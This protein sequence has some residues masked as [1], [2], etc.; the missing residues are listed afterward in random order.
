[1]PQL[2]NQ[3]RPRPGPGEGE[4]ARR[5]AGPGRG[6]TRPDDESTLHFAPETIILG[7]AYHVLEEG[8][9]REVSAPS[10]REASAR[11]RR[12]G[13]RPAIRRSAWRAM[14]NHDRLE[15]LLAVSRSVPLLREDD[16]MLLGV[17]DASK[18]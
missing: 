18:G 15:W 2:P 6:E 13:V 12:R 16:V 10:M 5:P 17:R 4:G 8:L 7:I 9:A 3:W 11:L 1:M 14:T